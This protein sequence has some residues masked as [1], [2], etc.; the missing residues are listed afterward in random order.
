MTIIDLLAHMAASMFV[1]L[2]SKVLVIDV[3][4]LGITDDHLSHLCFSKEKISVQDVAVVYI[5][6]LIHILIV[7]IDPSR[8]SLINP[9]LYEAA[10]TFAGH[11]R[12]PTHVLIMY[13]R[14]FHITALLSFEFL[15]VV[16]CRLWP[17]CTSRC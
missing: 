11:A 17:L 16:P 5:S 1:P 3:D 10:F 12:L 6:L 9:L 2:L 13:I 15:K 7:V 8:L 14:I 4:T